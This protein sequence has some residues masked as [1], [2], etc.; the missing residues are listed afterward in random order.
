VA[1]LSDTLLLVN[2]AAQN[3]RLFRFSVL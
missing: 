2:V 1:V 3:L